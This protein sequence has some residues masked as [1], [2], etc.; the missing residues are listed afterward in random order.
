MHLDAAKPPKK[1]D[2]VTT[3]RSYGIPIYITSVDV[4]LKDVS[5]TPEQ[6]YQV[7]ANVFRDMLEAALESGVCS[8]FGIWGIGDKYSWIEWDKT[9]PLNSPIGDPTPFDDDYSP[10]PAYFAMLDVLKNAAGLR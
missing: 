4:N 7:Q 2:V 8:N 10:K 9:Y 1:A 3:M 6:R 5:G